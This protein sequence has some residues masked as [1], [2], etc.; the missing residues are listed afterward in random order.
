MLTF[1]FSR[2]LVKKAEEERKIA[3]GT[4]TL[5][6]EANANGANLPTYAHATNGNGASTAQP[7]RPEHAKQ[8]SGILGGLFGSRSRRADE[9]MGMSSVPPNLTNQQKPTR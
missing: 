5:V 2:Y 3:A 6:Q 7:M 9:E 1:P 4:S 8:Q